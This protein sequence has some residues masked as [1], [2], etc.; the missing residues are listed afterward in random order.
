MLCNQKR[1]SKETFTQH[2]QNSQHITCWVLITPNLIS[3][4]SNIALGSDWTD[5][6]GFEGSLEC[7]CL[8]VFLP[9]TLWC[10][11][12]KK[13]T[14]KTVFG[15]I[16]EL[17]L[18]SRNRMAIRKTIEQCI[19]QDGEKQGGEPDVLPLCMVVQTQFPQSVYNI[20]LPLHSMTDWLQGYHWRHN[21]I[22]KNR[23]SWENHQSRAP[24]IG[25]F[26]DWKP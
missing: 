25:I 23:K 22:F 15:D 26:R 1:K 18:C 5:M 11:L 4:G 10:H 12:C 21:K 8:C 3:S 20:G 9:A 7:V 14:V 2:R 13:L 17:Y 6:D 19:M 24:F 16:K